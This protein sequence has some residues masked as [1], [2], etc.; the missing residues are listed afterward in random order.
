MANF[1]EALS[2][3]I[4]TKL[5][6]PSDVFFATRTVKGKVLKG[7]WYRIFKD[8]KREEWQTFGWLGSDVDS[9]RKAIQELAKT[10]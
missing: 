5:G 7:Y 9:A 6:Q 1:S 3:E 2:K 10:N 8:D 4:E